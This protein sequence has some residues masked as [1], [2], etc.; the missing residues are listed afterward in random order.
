MT[1][2]R[3]LEIADHI[4][5]WCG[6]PSHEFGGCDATIAELRAHAD[7]LE[8]NGEWRDISTAPKDGTE[9]I[10]VTFDDRGDVQHIDVGCWS[11]W[12]EDTFG[13]CSMTCRGWTSNCWPFSDAGP[14]HWQ[15]LP[16]PPEAK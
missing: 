8:R 7:Q 5:Q 13:G 4:Y 2:Q 12:Q 15:P 10:M 16:K 6:C 14:T 9:I 1:P 11:E 3:L